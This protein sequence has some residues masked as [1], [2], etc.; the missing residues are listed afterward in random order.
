VE[1]KKQNSDFFSIIFILIDILYWLESYKLRIRVGEQA[2]SVFL[3][4]FSAINTRLDQ[5]S[6][7]ED[8]SKTKRRLPTART[9][10]YKMMSD[11][12]I[13]R[14]EDLIKNISA[15]TTEIQETIIDEVRDSVRETVESAKSSTDE[16]H[17]EHWRLMILR[18]ARIHFEN[19]NMDSF[20]TILYRLERD[21]YWK[22]Y[23]PQ[24]VREL[25]MDD[26]LSPEEVLRQ[27]NKQDVTKKK[28]VIEEKEKEE[29][30]RHEERQKQIE[31]LKQQ[32]T[33]EREK[34]LRQLEQLFETIKRLSADKTKQ[35]E[36]ETK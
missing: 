28:I 23:D 15:S 26:D 19:N 10:Q 33:E 1:K 32:L 29:Q 21:P 30:K 13:Q 5:I 9:E 7:N 12:I 3:Q 6:I 14:T 36:E 22:G 4:Q 17:E 16:E 34:G 35:E 18:G 11:E 31:E 2:N 27:L 25:I 8:A 20:N 24:S